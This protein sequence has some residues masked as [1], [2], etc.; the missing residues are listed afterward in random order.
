MGSR[1]TKLGGGTGKR[2]L[3]GPTLV[4]WSSRAG[5]SVQRAERGR[6][7]VVRLTGGQYKG[8]LGLYD[9]DDG[10]VAIVY[11]WG[12]PPAA[13]V[14]CRPS[15][16][17]AARDDEVKLWWVVNGNQIATRILLQEFKQRHERSE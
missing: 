1:K 11:P 12:P 10:G 16:M 4:A 5:E 17:A 6:Y 13:Y 2:P 15:S 3:A 14:V 8:F 7:R 9:D